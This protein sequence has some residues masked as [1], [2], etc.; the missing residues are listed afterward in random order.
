MLKGRAENEFSGA[1]AFLA[2]SAH[3]SARSERAWTQAP[4]TRQDI[5]VIW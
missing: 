3:L 5:Y 1:I 4:A 2:D